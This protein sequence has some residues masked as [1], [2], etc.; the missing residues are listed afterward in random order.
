[1]SLFHITRHSD[2]PLMG[3]LYFGVVDR[4][5]NLLQIRPSCGCNLN[6]PFCSVDAG[7]HSQSRV[8]DYQ[9][10]LD[11]LLEAVEEIA[12]FKGPGVE[13][14]IDSPGEPMLYPD[15]V[16]LVRQLKQIKE[17]AVVSMQS[18]GTLLDAD[19]IKALEEAG[20]DRINLS[21]HALEPA[22]AAY[23]AGVPW[24][25]IEK[26]KKA[27]KSIAESKIDLMIAPVYMPG[28]NDDE[29]PGLIE[30]A[31]KVGAGKRWPPLGIQKF[32]HY[33]LGRS[34]GK[35]K[36][37]NWWHFYNRSMK[38]W[39][40]Q[41]S[42]PLL[43]RAQDFG[44]EKRPTI[45]TVFEKKEKAWVEIRA[46]GWVKGEQLGVARNRVVSVM[47]CP[48]KQGSVRVRIVSNKHNIYVGVP[49]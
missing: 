44:I 25:D 3:C 15:I 49:C 26:V 38:S 29:M 21:I 23:L 22:K 11:Y 7:P 32:E 16:E 10:E 17:V 43:L 28:I 5:S 9:V 13:C 42:R 47:D 34:P 31:L 20:L 8:T 24:Y 37:E 4:G 41:S 6:C 46:P 33:R 2:I 39:E 45:P 19:R 48:V 12:P 30:F 27:A 40:E 1:M 14:H 18:N 36:A 35:I